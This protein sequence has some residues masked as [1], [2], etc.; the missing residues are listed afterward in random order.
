M[1]GFAK[2]CRFPSEINNLLLVSVLLQKPLPEEEVWALAIS[3]TSF[4]MFHPLFER[5]VILDE[6][7]ISCYYGAK[8]IFRQKIF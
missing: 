7:P 1:A 3:K 8:A 6:F 5:W 2:R 4:S